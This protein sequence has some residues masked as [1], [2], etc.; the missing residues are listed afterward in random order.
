MG[1][2]RGQRGGEK[3]TVGSDRP[4]PAELGASQPGLFFKCFDSDHTLRCEVTSDVAK[5]LNMCFL[6]LIL[7]TN[8]LNENLDFG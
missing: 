4:F 3:P 1:I 8:V 6:I 7:W 5:W 2:M